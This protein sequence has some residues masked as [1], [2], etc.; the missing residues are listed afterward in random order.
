[1]IWSVS[2]KNVWRNH[3]R[4][5][6]VICAVVL[7]TVAGVFTSALIKGWTDQRVRSAIYTEASHIKLHNPDYLIN[8][9]IRHT[10]A[11]GEKAIATLKGNPDIKAF[12]PRIKIMAMA[13][14]SRGNTGVMLVGVD[15]EKEKAVS[16][17]FEFIVENGGEYLDGETK[18]Q[19]VISDKIAEQLSIKNYTIDDS[20]IDTLLTL[21]VS[22]SVVEKLQALNGRRFTTERLINKELD[23]ILTDQ[24]GKKYRS[25]IL[26]V[27]R[28]YRLR[29]KI[30]FTFSGLDGQMLYQS[31][32]V[33]GI[34]KTSNTMFDQMNAF[35]MQSDL[36]AVSGVGENDFHEVGIILHDGERIEPFAENIK[37]ALPGISALSWKELAPDAGMLVD[38]MDIYY[39]VIMGFI[40]F[41][42]AFGIINTM[43][44][45]ILE[46]IKELGMLMAIGMNKK[47]VFSM[48]MLETVFLTLTGAIIGM[49]IAAVLVAVT[50]HTGLNF[51]SVAEGFEAMGWAALV[52][53]DI[54]PS[55][56]IGVTVM[57]I[58]TG[59]L[60]S[61]IPARKALKLN[62]VE[63]IHME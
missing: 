13:G 50:N 21:G 52:Y 20:A 37:A 8:E 39:F 63:A 24:E 60:S 9:E 16:N 25:Q 17:V 57:V 40:L 10:I 22:G 14:T 4:S 19:V 2:W 42:L 7:G 47:R 45:A 18:N 26:T 54:E 28:H 46:R 44:M 62:P 56:F 59:I 49:A 12:S 51:S 35:V 15:P 32:R 38:Y 6:V 23:K 58:V 29:S 1:M 55:Y 5:L 36:S 48:I 53:P 11:D 33:C 31:Y 30:V 43:L 27:A 3:K 34:F 61:I 41:A